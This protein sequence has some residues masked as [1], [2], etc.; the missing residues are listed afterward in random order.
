M[1]FLLEFLYRSIITQA[2][3]PGQSLP[4]NPAYS[5]YLSASLLGFTV[6]SAQAG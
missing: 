4:Q 6:I 2:L 5:L 1:L 3:P